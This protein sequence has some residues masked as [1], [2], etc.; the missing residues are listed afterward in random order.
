MFW[1]SLLIFMC[2][3]LNFFFFFSKKYF[4]M[5]FLGFLLKKLEKENKK[6]NS[7][8]KID[9]GNINRNNELK[10]SET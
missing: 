9:N 10:W 5:N 1:N 4:L 6:F 8:S 2:S 3:S 7:K